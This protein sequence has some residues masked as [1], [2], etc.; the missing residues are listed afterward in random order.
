MMI[1]GRKLLADEIEAGNNKFSAK[2]VD[3]A[4]N[5]ES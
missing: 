4:K 3:I 1:S 2:I 5:N